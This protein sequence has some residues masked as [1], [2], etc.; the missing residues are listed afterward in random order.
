M[1]KKLHLQLDY[2]IE[3]FVEVRTWNNK[4][5]L[6]NTHAD[7]TQYTNQHVKVAISNK[8]QR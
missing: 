8:K 1:G 7:N 6:I 3:K 4:N 5:K 2:I